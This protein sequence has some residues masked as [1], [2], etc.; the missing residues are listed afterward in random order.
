[1]YTSMDGSMGSFGTRLKQ[2]SLL[3]VEGFREACC[4]HRV[5]IYCRRSREVAIRT[6]QCFLLNGIIFLGSILVLRS[7]VIPTLQWVLPDECQLINYQESCP[8]GGIFRFYSFLRLGLIQLFYV[9]WFYPM[10]IS[11]FIL[12]TL[13]Y[14]DIA[15]YGFFAIEKNGASGSEL[16]DKKDSTA[17]QNMSASDKTTDLEGVMIGIAEQVYSVLLLS[18][19]F[20]E[21]Y[22]TGFI[23]YIGKALNFLLLVWMYAYYCFEYKWNYSGVSLDKRLDFFE[24][25]WPFFAGFG[26]PCILAVF[27]YSPLVSYGVMATLYPLFVLTATGSEADKAIASQR[28]KWKGAGLGRIPIFVSADYLSMKVLSLFPMERRQQVVHNQKAL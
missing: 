24:S 6:G 25:N 27:F 10:Y 21:V 16:S 18:F 14:N 12:S 3:W 17:S 15:K 2:A 1:M 4:L 22:I 13:W 19:F 9:F 5:V 7:V 8:F 20:L 11:S 26:S 23:P 28:K